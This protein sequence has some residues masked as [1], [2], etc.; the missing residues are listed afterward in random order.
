LVAPS[1]TRALQTSGRE[2]P[3]AFTCIGQSWI[4]GY[5]RW[6]VTSIKCLKSTAKAFLLSQQ[7]K[8]VLRTAEEPFCLRP[9]KNVSCPG[10]GYVSQISHIVSYHLP[11]PFPQVPELGQKPNHSSR[12][13]VYAF[14]PSNTI[15]LRATT[16][17]STPRPPGSLT[18]GVPS[19]SARTL[20]SSHQYLPALASPVSLLLHP[21]S[22]YL[23]PSSCLFLPTRG[24]RH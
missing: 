11:D 17:T 4:L 18:I 14:A 5:V 23:H 22:S 1:T 21:V 20:Q 16:Y 24:N 9:R 8:L 3:R 6:Y 15:S 10:L 13:A 19:H 2:M 7:R 12:C